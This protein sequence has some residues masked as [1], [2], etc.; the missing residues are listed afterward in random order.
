[1]CLSEA[2]R[3]G[4]VRRA[5][6]LTLDDGPTLCA[7]LAV[8]QLTFNSMSCSLGH[9]KTI[10]PSNQSFVLSCASIHWCTELV[11]YVSFGPVSSSPQLYH[12]LH[13]EVHPGRALNMPS[14]HLLLLLSCVFWARLITRPH[15]SLPS[16]LTA[17]LYFRCSHSG[18][19]LQLNEP[20]L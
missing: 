5:V 18:L 20:Q 1:M 10:H 19:C 7:L 3:L 2:Y 15:F 17:S 6:T 9:E 14:S 16:P 4:N 8:G 12:Q 11:L 13:A